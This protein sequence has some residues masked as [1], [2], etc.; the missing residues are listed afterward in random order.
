MKEEK[1][2]MVLLAKIKN[3]LTTLNDI[4]EM[5]K[6]NGERLSK[7]DNELSDWLEYI[8]RNE[9]NSYQSEQVLNRI[10]T[11]KKL[12]KELRNEFAIERIYQKYRLGL[13]VV[14]DRENLEKEIEDFCGNKDKNEDY[15]VL[16]EEKIKATL[17][18]EIT[19]VEKERTSTYGKSRGRKNEYSFEEM[20]KL[21]MKGMSYCQISKELNCS[22]STV[23]RAFKLHKAQRRDNQMVLSK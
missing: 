23:Q 8:Q 18:P 14:V 19:I 10:K 9:L 7:V 2:D 20:Y 16:D 21:Y 17:K 4:E 11:L 22:Y 6:T 3:V 13:G 15:K 12:R 5:C 1:I